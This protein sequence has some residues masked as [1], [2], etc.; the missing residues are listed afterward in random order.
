MTEKLRGGTLNV[1]GTPGKTVV[2]TLQTTLRGIQ[3]EGQGAAA[4]QVL[5]R[6]GALNSRRSRRVALARPI[7]IAAK[8]R[9]CT[10]IAPD[11]PQYPGE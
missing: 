8:P 3:S 5:N 7:G 2:Y 6:P 10:R 9:V 4:E 11:A 1:T